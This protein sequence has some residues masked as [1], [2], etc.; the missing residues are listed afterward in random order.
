MVTMEASQD[1]RLWQLAA[2]V[3]TVQS[4]NIYEMELRQ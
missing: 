2:L 3:N 4:Y 1:C